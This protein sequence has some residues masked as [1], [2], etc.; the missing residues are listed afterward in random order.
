M[1][2]V[3]KVLKVLLIGTAAI[4]V[5]GEVVQ[6]LWNWLVPG[7]FG[8]HAVSFAQALGLLVLSWILFGGFRGRGPGGGSWRRGMRD[9]W[10]QMTP[11]ERAKFKDGMRG[12]CGSRTAK[13]EPAAASA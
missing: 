5:F 11:E 6:Q 13:N 9:R 2:R 1:R 7:I 10:E 4:A 3:G 8:W 12:R